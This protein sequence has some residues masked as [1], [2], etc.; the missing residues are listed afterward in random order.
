MAFDIETIFSDLKEYFDEANYVSEM[1]EKYPEVVAILEDLVD[2]FPDLAFL[3][4]TL[5]RTHVALI[6]CF[7]QQGTV[8]LCG[9]GGSHADAVH[10]VGEL[11]KSFERDRTMS[12]EQKKTFEGLPDADALT[13]NLECG[14]RGYALGASAPLATAI[15]NDNEVRDI[16]YAQE[17]FAMAK[18]G[19]VFIGIS[20]SGNARNVNLALQVAEALGLCTIGMSGEKGGTL[21]ETA[22][23][24]IKAP[25][26]V[27]KMV[28]ELHLPIYHAI[29]AMIE[30][31]Y[32][33]KM[34]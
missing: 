14:L 12:D 11:L 33:P 17:L 10:I 29:C 7:D 9:N 1:G 20:T 18:P 30:A 8:F 25:A 27:T 31:H 16:S 5:I 22:K 26:T 13:K 4:S 19:D 24:A 28:Q 15:H 6:K 2:R 21:C 32:F 23:I 34:R 3:A